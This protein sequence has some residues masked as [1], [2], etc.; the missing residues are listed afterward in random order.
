MNGEKKLKPLPGACRPGSRGIGGSTSDGNSGKRGPGPAPADRLGSTPP[1][2]P[3]A[4]PPEPN[5]DHELE[6]RDMGSA[7]TG[8]TNDA[9]V[10]KNGSDASAPL[11][12]KP[13]GSLSENS[14]DDSVEEPAL[15]VQ[16]VSLDRCRA[17]RLS[18]SRT[19][20]GSGSDG[21]MLAADTDDGTALPAGAT[22]LE[23][24]MDT[25][26]LVLVVSGVTV[27]PTMMGDRMTGG[28]LSRAPTGDPTA[29]R[30]TPLGAALASGSRAAGAAAAAEDGAAAAADA[31]PALA[32]ADAA[33]G[34]A[35]PTVRRAG[36]VVAA[37]LTSG[38]LATAGTAAAAAPLPLL[39][40]PLPLALLLLEL[41]LP[42]LLPLLLL[43]GAAFAGAAAGADGA[44]AD[45]PADGA[46]PAAVD[47]ED[48]DAA[49][50]G[51]ALLGRAAVWRPRVA[52]D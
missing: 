19:R 41:L 35:A 4:T 42:L 23:G 12:N 39:P 17:G 20:V 31:G 21:A 13:T 49:L 18:S 33:A 9:A 44:E 16:S 29:G 28:T 11:S 46:V 2:G 24:K 52:V 1:V 6:R 38:L 34:A 14:G 51:G 22:P 30:G 40:L 27:G 45:D 10:G 50:V 48:D 47:D 5:S 15:A 36:V 26:A 43:A 3:F 7:S 32:L 8:G 25:L 37:A